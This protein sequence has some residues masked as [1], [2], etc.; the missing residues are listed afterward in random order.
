MAATIVRLYVPSGLDRSVCV[1]DCVGIAVD[2]AVRVAVLVRVGVDVSVGVGVAVGV[3][4]AVSVATVVGLAVAVAVSVVVVAPDE[5]GVAVPS[6]TV[7]V[8]SCAFGSSVRLEQPAESTSSMIN[9][10]TT[11]RRIGVVDMGRNSLPCL[12][13]LHEPQSAC[14]RLQMSTGVSA[15]FST[16]RF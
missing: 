9:E 14:R 5:S 11:V 8:V 6:S 1:E 3:F 16:A 13:T 10:A 12:I 7:L 2:V 4:V 15:S